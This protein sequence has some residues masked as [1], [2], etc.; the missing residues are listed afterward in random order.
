M[1]PQEK[2]VIVNP[3]ESINV[4]LNTPLIEQRDR[5]NR[6]DNANFLLR[7]EQT[8]LE[9]LSNSHTALYERYSR[10]PFYSFSTRRIM[11]QT[12]NHLTADIGQVSDNIRNLEESISELQNDNQE[13]QN[14]NQDLEA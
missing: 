4:A 3:D 9:Q 12:L 14:D 8:R 2:I 13:L 5:Q 6:L 10:L 7:T 1:D 11:L